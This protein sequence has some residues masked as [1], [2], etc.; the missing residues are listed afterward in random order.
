MIMNANT[1]L[2]SS[3]VVLIGLQLCAPER[4]N[5]FVMKSNEMLWTNNPLLRS[6]HGLCNLVGTVVVLGFTA[7]L[8]FSEEWWYI[9]VYIGG[10]ILAKIIAI[11]IKLLLSPLYKN[12]PSSEIRIQRIVGI[13]LIVAGLL[14]FLII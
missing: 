9:L 8:T 3:F 13:I 1:I 5:K 2:I 7:Y 14:C 12:N 11:L 4:N 6:I 10:F